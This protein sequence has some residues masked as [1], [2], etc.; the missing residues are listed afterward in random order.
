MSDTTRLAL[1]RLDAAQAQKHVTHN[2]ALGLLDALVHLSVSARNL[3]APPTAPVE[4]ARFIVGSAPTGA[5]AGQAGKVA[6]FDDGAWRFLAPKKGWCAF[7]ESESRLVVSTAPAGRFWLSTFRKRR[8]CA[9]LASAL[10][11]T[12]IHPCWRG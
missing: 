12:Q 7:V 10:W 4:G 8:T 6:A 11:R 2:E 1:P 3:A 9:V 5:F